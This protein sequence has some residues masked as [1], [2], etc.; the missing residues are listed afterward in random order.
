MYGD[1]ARLIPVSTDERCE[2]AIFAGA[3]GGKDLVQ[4]EVADN[5]EANPLRLRF[6]G[7]GRLLRGFCGSVEL[8]EIDCILL[9]RL[10]QLS[11]DC[12]PGRKRRGYELDCD[13]VKQVQRRL[14]LLPRIDLQIDDDV[15]FAV[16]GADGFYGALLSSGLCPDL[17]VCRLGELPE[18]VPAVVIR[19][20]AFDR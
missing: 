11:I 2:L 7:R 12:Y 8:G 16:E 3:E 6:G 1:F 19:D 18:A 15:V 20:E 14:P 17:I 10:G 5:G 13:A 4:R 9:V